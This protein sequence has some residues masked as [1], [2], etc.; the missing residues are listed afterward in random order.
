[1]KLYNS[2]LVTYILQYKYKENNHSIN[3]P[4]RLTY[5]TLVPI[6]RIN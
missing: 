1:M 6:E 5:C 4:V 3:K 2:N